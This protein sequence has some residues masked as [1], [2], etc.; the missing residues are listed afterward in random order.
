MLKRN[1]LRLERRLGYGRLRKG[2]LLRG[3]ERNDGGQ[4][5]PSGY[6]VG[7]TRKGK[8][9]GITHEDVENLREVEFEGRRAQLYG[10]HSRS[11]RGEAEAV[12]LELDV[13]G[14][15]RLALYGYFDGSEFFELDREYAD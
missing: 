15:S 10:A 13:F 14:G 7:M 8:P 2:P 12:R 5:V 6:T 11:R 3:R 4:A 1:G 9:T